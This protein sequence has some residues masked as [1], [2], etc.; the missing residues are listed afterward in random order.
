[1]VNDELS[2]NDSPDSPFTPARRSF[3]EGGIHHSPLWLEDES[4]RIGLVNI[5][6]DLWNT[7]R[8]S[9]VYF[10]D[11]P[12]DERLKHIVAEYGLLDKQKM[13]D[14]ILR[15]RERL[16][17]LE[18]KK[19]IEFLDQNNFIESFR[20][21]LKYYDKWYSKGLHN[22]EGL[23]ALLYTVKCDSVTPENANKLA[24]QPLHY[25]NP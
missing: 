23:N 24:R 12:F 5:P 8:K 4:Q 22:R 9:P 15:I 20:I 3:I 14:A 25:E 1:M 17:G 19:A 2:I 11:I 6:N 7:M 10:L 13:T 18:A 21:L 16:G